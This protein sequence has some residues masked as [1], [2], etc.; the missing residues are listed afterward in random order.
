MC[1]LPPTREITVDFSPVPP[2]DRVEPE[3][4]GLDTYLIHQLQPALGAPLSVYINSMVITGAEPVIVDTG[5]IANRK[6][7]LDVPSAR[8]ARRRSGCSSRTTTST[9]PATSKR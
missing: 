2:T 9:T 6:Q 3:R 5:T 8:G 4:V 7:W 1:C